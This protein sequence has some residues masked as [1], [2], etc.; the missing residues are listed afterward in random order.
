MPGTPKKVYKAG[1]GL[2]VITYEKSGKISR[3]IAKKG[4][5][6][7]DKQ[8]AFVN[9]NIS[10]AKNNLDQFKKRIDKRIDELASR[11]TSLQD[12]QDKVVQNIS[13]KV[14]KMGSDTSQGFKKTVDNIVKKSK[15]KK[16]Q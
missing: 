7:K 3:N 14:K 13:I 9:R 10:R 5:E 12:K 16:K 4:I 2:L 15:E 6:I 8:Q 11:G 1:L